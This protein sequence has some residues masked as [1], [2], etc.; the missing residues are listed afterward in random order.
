MKIYL[1]L[2]SIIILLPFF[3][4][5]QSQEPVDFENLVHFSKDQFPIGEFFDDISED[6]NGNMWFITYDGSPALKRNFNLSKFDGKNWTR[7]TKEDGL[8]S[9]KFRAVQCDSKG[10]VWVATSRGIC[11]FDGTN[12][13]ITTKQFV[14][15][16]IIFED[17]N[18]NIWAGGDRGG[19]MGHVCI[20][21]GDKWILQKTKGVDKSWGV[22]VIF[23]DSKRTIW[24]GVGSATKKRMGRIR[25]FDGS[26]WKIYKPKITEVNPAM[27]NK[28]VQTIVEDKR[29]NI[30]VGEGFNA[31]AKEGGGIKLYD[32]QKWKEFT[33]D[34]GLPDSR[35]LR[36]TDSLVDNNGNVWFTARALIYSIHGW[37]EFGGVYKFN[38]EKWTVF[39]IEDG[40]PSSM[41]LSILE[42]K[43]GNI[44]IG[45]DK[46]IARY[47][48]EY[49]SKVYSLSGYGNITEL[50]EDSKGNIWCV[51]ELGG[52]LKIE[53]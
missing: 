43:S 25:S 47:N 10:N 36:I 14:S 23:E 48:G 20:Y 46:G 19:I 5:S 35:N 4:Y 31:G 22:K 1:K 49:W 34:D 15:T 29:G 17:S 52:I 53:L 50:F 38:G 13:E 2:R 3:C 28:C 18:G 32:G 33:I 51:P 24:I 42:D 39:T 41:V 7:Y 26:N 8:A 44:W 6:T 11:R 16:K 9:N 27:P 37:G 21:D 40:I 30:W 45:T 12:W